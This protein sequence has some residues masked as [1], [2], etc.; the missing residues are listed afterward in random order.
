VLLPQTG[1]LMNN[2]IMWF[3]PRP[4][5]AN[6]LAPGKRPLSN[7]CPVVAQRADGAPWLALGASG[8]RSI[9]PAVLQVLSFVVAH[10]MSLDDAMHQPRIDVSG[11]AQVVAD[12][13]LPED[14]RAAL[15]QRFPTRLLEQRVQPGGYA[16]PCIV[17]AD[18]DGG[19]LGSADVM[20]PWS[21]AVAEDDA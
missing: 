15:A 12:P 2:G 7:M 6:S 16:C 4:G 20:S 13:R 21:A 10:G 19:H 5:A 8:G 11:G 9:L 17:L 1:V 3:D 18:A 14:V